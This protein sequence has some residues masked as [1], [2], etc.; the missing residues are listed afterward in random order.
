MVCVVPAVQLIP[1]EDGE[2]TV[3]VEG[4]AL[5]IEKLLLLMSVYVFVPLLVVSFILNAVPV[6]CVEDIGQL[7]DPAVK[8][9]PEDIVA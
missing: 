7:K 2:V 8:G 1:A 5:T 4:G 3:M 6:A 9:T